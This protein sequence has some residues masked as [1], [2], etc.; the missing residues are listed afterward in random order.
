MYTFKFCLFS[1]IWVSVSAGRGTF[2]GIKSKPFL[3][4]NCHE[5]LKRILFVGYHQ[6]CHEPNIPASALEFDAPWMCLYCTVGEVCPYLTNP[7][8]SPSTKRTSKKRRP[9]TVRE[10]YLYL[11]IELEYRCQVL[12]NLMLIEINLISKS[13][14]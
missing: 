6:S 7:F 4:Q 3:T 12:I 8:E 1:G 10:F 11:N 13:S 14:S 5:K 9:E 2:D